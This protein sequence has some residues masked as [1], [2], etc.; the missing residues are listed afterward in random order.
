MHD[1]AVHA[2]EVHAR[3][4]HAHETHDGEVHVHE[5]YPHAMHAYEMHAHEMHARK[6]YTHETPAHPLLWWRWPKQWSI[7]VSTSEFQKTRFCA[8]C[9][10]SLLPSALAPLLHKRRFT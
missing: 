5:V 4:V 6:V 7:Y 1:C 2:Y 8:S 3:E 10:W 9:G